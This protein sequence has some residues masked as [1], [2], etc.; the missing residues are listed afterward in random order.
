MSSTGHCHCVVFSL[1]NALNY[2]GTNLLGKGGN[3]RLM[4]KYI[5][6]KLRISSTSLCVRK[7]VD[8]VVWMW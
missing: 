8:G 1:G 5:Y 6:M 4:F 7:G 2:I 3:S